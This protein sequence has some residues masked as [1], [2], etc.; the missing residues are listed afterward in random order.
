MA[1]SVSATDVNNHEP[2]LPDFGLLVLPHQSYHSILPCPPPLPI[3]TG[4]ELANHPWDEDEMTQHGLTIIPGKYG[5]YTYQAHIFD[6]RLRR[7]YTVISPSYPD[8]TSDGRHAEELD[9]ICEHTY[10]VDVL[11]RTGHRA[12]DDFNIAVVKHTCASGG[13]GAP[14]AGECICAKSP[15]T[16]MGSPDAI[17]CPIYGLRSRSAIPVCANSKSNSSP[18]SIPDLQFIG[19]DDITNRRYLAQASELCTW[20]SSL[21]RSAC[22]RLESEDVDL[23]F[24]QI[25][26]TP[27]E[28]DWLYREMSLLRHLYLA[29]H[30]VS[31]L[32]KR[33]THYPFLPL[34]ACVVD[35]Q[36]L[37][38]GFLTPYGGKPLHDLPKNSIKAA[39]FVS[40]LRGV[41]TLHQIPDRMIRKMYRAS[42]PDDFPETTKGEPDM[43]QHGDIC[44][45][46]VLFDASTGD[47]WLID[48]GNMGIDYPGDRLALA[49]MIRTLREAPGASSEQEGQLM[50][51][52]AE[53]LRGG[54]SFE[55]IV[56]V[57]EGNLSSG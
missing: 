15:I 5:T 35:S 2:E 8:K 14:E 48:A 44:A 23:V 53:M 42:M 10:W 56:R 24:K 39:F 6:I 37:V 12:R 28:A 33:R 27:L 52:M 22:P 13:Y 36:D 38:R 7:W 55:E 1:G 20:P 34:I 17:G 32:E 21:N 47:V 41:L 45:R 50:D 54:V 4:D 9:S 26:L 29:S 19:I 30:S 51:E 3:L 18:S 11:Q 40:V 57:F 16:Y 49:E 43:V 31:P 25:M 46:N